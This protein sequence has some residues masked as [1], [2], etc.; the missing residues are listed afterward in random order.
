MNN[1]K[2]VP[3]LPPTY[4]LVSQHNRPTSRTQPV[5][6]PLIHA[7]TRITTHLPTPEGFSGVRISWPGWLTNSGHLTHEVVTCQP[8]TDKGKAGSQRPTP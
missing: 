8:G 3:L 1:K 2:K 6:T 4:Y 5:S 7:I